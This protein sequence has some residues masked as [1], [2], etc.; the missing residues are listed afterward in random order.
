MS[1]AATLTATYN[2]LE[3]VR[4]S[5]EANKG[6][7]AGVI[8]EPVVGN[9]GFIPPT[10]EFLEVLTSSCLQAFS[11]LSICTLKKS[12]F[13]TV[14]IRA[15]GTSTE[16]ALWMPVLHMQCLQVALHLRRYT[17][18]AVL[19]GHAVFAT[20]FLPH[21]QGLRQICTEH[22]ALLCFDEVMTGFRIAKGCAQEHFGI[23]PDLTTVR[24]LSPISPCS[25][26]ANMTCLHVASIKMV[27]S[28]VVRA[29]YDAAKDCYPPCSQL[30]RTL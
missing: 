24:C 16:S 12:A 18:T 11:G 2:D 17:I 27:W 25:I 22:G 30:T 14:K 28:S 1:A 26:R 9:S 8:L 29:A 6:E 19:V 7:I 23:T 3:S 5:F 21:M 15:I 13:M 4:Q 20:F 10:Q